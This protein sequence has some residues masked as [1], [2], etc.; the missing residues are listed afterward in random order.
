M[1]IFGFT[2]SNFFIFYCSYINLNGTGVFGVVIWNSNF[3]Y[4]LMV[5]HSSSGGVSDFLII[6][7]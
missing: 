2:L 4:L 5:H 1:P 6:T 3:P 7:L